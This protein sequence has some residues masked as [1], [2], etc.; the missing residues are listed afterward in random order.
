MNNVTEMQDKVISLLSEVKREGI[1]NLIKFIKE[2][3]YLTTATCY[4]HHKSAYGLMNHSLEVLDTM[5]K[6]NVHGFP[7]ESLILLALCHDLGK[8]RLN[9]RHVARGSHPARS[10]YILGKCG[11]PLSEME[12]N[13]IR[14]HHPHDLAG[15]AKVA[16]NP[17]AGLLSAGD[18]NSARLNK[19]GRVY[20]FTKI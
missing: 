19:K 6:L 4:K 13:A 12:K 5:L 9:G 1:D 3:D 16:S 11:V 15:Y 2:S 7:R 18:C 14:G 17:L 8:A 20:S 10:V